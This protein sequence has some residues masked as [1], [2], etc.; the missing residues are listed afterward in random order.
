MTIIET[1]RLI[2]RNFKSG[3]W[4]ALH[5]IILKYQASGMVQYDHPWPA[6]Q[7]EIRKIAEYFSNGDSFLAV[8]LKASNQLIGFV[9]LNPEET[10]GSH[11]A[12]LG[13]V[14]DTDFHGLGYATEACKA[15]LSHAFV[16]LHKDQAV[17]GTAA[18]NSYSCRLLE[19]LGFLKTG[20]EIVS[21]NTDKNGKPVKFLGYRYA[22][23]KDEWAKKTSTT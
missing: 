2:I 3:D 22:I 7:E 5:G 19:R 17:T 18:I 1:D 10:A 23:S 9:N 20:E 21:F 13:Y 4:Q 16:Q 8:C 11:D 14:F 15:V 12:S 6:S